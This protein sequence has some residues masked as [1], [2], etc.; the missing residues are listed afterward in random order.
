MPQADLA[1][2]LGVTRFTI[3]RWESGGKPEEKYLP[4]IE[5]ETGIPKSVVHR[6]KSR[7]AGQ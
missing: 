1:T 5:K 2:R 3:I 4:A 7:S 6:M